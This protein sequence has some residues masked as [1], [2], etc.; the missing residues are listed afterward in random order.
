MS[1]D[2]TGVVEPNREVPGA[3]I[4]DSLSCIEAVHSG[5]NYANQVFLYEQRGLQERTVRP[6][7]FAIAEP[8]KPE[9]AAARVCGRGCSVICSVSTSPST[10]A[11]I[12][13]TC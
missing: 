13:V 8:V 9:R 5:L 7:V 12:V 2:S 6:R 11:P 3:D 10:T 4:Q 1:G